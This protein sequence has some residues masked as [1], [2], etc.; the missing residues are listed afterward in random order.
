MPRLSLAALPFVALPLLSGCFP[1][2][3]L[4]AAFGDSVTWGY[5]GSPGGWV[6]DLEKRTDEPIANLGVPGETSA[7]AEDR[8]SGPF[9]LALAPQAEIVL[10]L[11]G[12]NDMN[13]AFHR[14]PCSLTCDPHDIPEVDEKYVRIGNHLRSIAKKADKGRKVVF[15]TYWPPNPIACPDYSAEEFAGFQMAIQRINEEIVAVAAEKGHFVVRLD[16]IPEYDLDP[17]NYYDCLHPS[18]EGY[19]KIATRWLTDKDEW[20][21]ANGFRDE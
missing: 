15:A 21:P 7:E 11:H 4:V 14:S 18:G 6:S 13:Q 20:L 2:Q 10:L 8:V 16:D 3:S 12:G 17:R 5:G 1:S 19:E 9:G